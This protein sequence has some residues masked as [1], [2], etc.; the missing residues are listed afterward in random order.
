MAAEE[1]ARRLHWRVRENKCVFSSYRLSD[2]KN[3]FPPL[4]PDF[5]GLV[6]ALT[7]NQ[8]S[9]CERMGHPA[10]PGLICEAKANTGILLPLRGNRVMAKAR[11]NAKTDGKTENKNK[12]RSPSGMTNK[13]ALVRG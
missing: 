11:V 4:K 10:G 2:S 9:R 5:G 3:A 13:K 1:G 6:R 8:L 12:R 7:P